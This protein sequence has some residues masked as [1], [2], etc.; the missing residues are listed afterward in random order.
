V[1]LFLVAASALGL[2]VW[3]PQTGEVSLEEL[4]RDTAAA[5]RRHALAL[6]AAGQWA[7][8][9]A[10]LRKLIAADPHGEWVTEARFAMARG[11]IAVGRCKTAFEELERLRIEHAGG[12]LAERA[13][14]LQLTAAR[15]EG[16]SDVDAAF[17]LFDRLIDTSTR[18]EE[19]ALIQKEKADAAFDAKRYMTARDEYGA[20]ANLYPNSEW[21]PY[22]LYR[23]A[24]CEWQM[25][26]WL[27]LGSERLRRAERMFTEFAEMFPT[28]A[29]AAKA[30]ER[31][32]LA[33]A[34][35]AEFSRRVAEFYIEARRRPWAAMSHLEYI[36][37]EF[38]GTPQAEWAAGEMNRIR[39]QSK[40]P[41][42]GETRPLVLPG[43][44]AKAAPEHSDEDSGR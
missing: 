22:C 21:V 9:V 44:R 28:H 25:A 35:R 34:R 5:K 12:P 32:A 41:L 11:L 1:G 43:V 13:R 23:M 36:C 7:G 26:R 3:T 6:I 10:E 30:K 2:E 29:Y 16:A 20:L 31:A 40:A 18:A 8:G 38:P 4:P 37:D 17:G 27:G 14:K 15:M 39:E 33:R 24:D 42:R 19:A